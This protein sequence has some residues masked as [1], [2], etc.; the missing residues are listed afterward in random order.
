MKLNSKTREGARGYS[1]QA[2]LLELNQDN[3]PL[4]QIGGT[5][6]VGSPTTDQLQLG[7]E[8]PNVQSAI[9]DITTL[10]QVP[11]NGVVMFAD[12]ATRTPAGISMI[13]RLE[14]SGETKKAGV[15]YVYGIPVAVNKGDNQDLITTN[16]FTILNKYKDA[17]IAIRK[18]EKVAGSNKQLDVTF[19]DTHHHENYIYRD[20]GISI[21]GSTTSVAVPGYGTWSKIGTQT[22]NFASADTTIHYYKRIS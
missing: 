4:G 13:E 21:I 1:R 22:L 7:V 20:N 3:L 6:K 11:I 8:F 5:T 15:V 14:I 10:Y 16:A 17:G 18:V 2:G 9:D 19:N 12:D